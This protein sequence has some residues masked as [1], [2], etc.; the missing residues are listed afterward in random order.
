MYGIWLMAICTSFWFV[1][2][3]NLRF[4]LWSASDAGRWPLDVFAGWIRFLLVVV[5]P[6]GV[7]TTFPAMALRGT[8]SWGLVAT[9]VAVGLGFLLASRLAWNRA[10]GSYTSASS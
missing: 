10:L 7:V 2:V 5:L 3:D 8:W 9:G 4:L 1:R 6:V